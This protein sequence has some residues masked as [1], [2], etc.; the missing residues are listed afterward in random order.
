MLLD[1]GA[2]PEEEV[3]EVI[4]TVTSRDLRVFAPHLASW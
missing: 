1:G 4:A 2:F 3:D